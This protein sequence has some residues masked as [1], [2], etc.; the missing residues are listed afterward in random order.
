M[1]TMETDLIVDRAEFEQRIDSIYSKRKNGNKPWSRKREAEI[2]SFLKGCEIPDFKKTLQHRHYQT[3]YDL[4]KIDSSKYIICLKRKNPQDPLIHQILVEEYCPKILEAH[5]KTGH[6]GR[7]K[8]LHYMRDQWVVTKDT[9]SLLVSLCKTCSRRKTAPKARVVVKL[10]IA[11][12]F[13]MKGQ[14]DLIDF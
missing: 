13:N 11:N 2:I 3:L 5:L 4:V 12:E 9:C 7:D 10:I 1:R 6:E 8:I 14:V